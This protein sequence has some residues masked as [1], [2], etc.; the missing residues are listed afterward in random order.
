MSNFSDSFLAAALAWDG[1][2]L[3]FFNLQTV[4]ASPIL[5]E[6]YSIYLVNEEKDGIPILLGFC[7]HYFSV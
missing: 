6:Q 4:S 7:S 5:P 3:T 2:G 1:L